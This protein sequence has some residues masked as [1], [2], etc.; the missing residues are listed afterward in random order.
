[1]TERVILTQPRPWC[2]E[3]ICGGRNTYKSHFT[4]IGE[5]DTGGGGGGDF[6]IYDKSK[7]RKEKWAKFR[8][9]ETRF[10]DGGTNYLHVPPNPSVSAVCRVSNVRHAL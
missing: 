4:G 5:Q 8:N 10:T 3:P 1:M 2:S 6:E 7:K 9:V